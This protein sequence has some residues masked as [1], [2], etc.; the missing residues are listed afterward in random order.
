MQEFSQFLNSIDDPAKRARTE[1]VLRWVAESF[2]SLGRRIAWNQPIF[3][4]EGT[5]II[6]FSLAKQHLAVAPEAVTLKRFEQDI[7][8][9]GYTCTK[10]LL[11]IP[12][13]REV[14]YRLLKDMIAF[15]MEDKK[16]HKAFWRAPEKQEP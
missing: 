13:D 12:W 7:R 11:R 1:Q 6:A 2:P 8:Q 14:D 3:T 9:A 5:F 10:M 15:N 16:G 4:Q